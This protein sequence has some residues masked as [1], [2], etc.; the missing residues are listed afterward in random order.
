MADVKGLNTKG[1]VTPMRNK[2][3]QQNATL[4]LPFVKGLITGFV[5]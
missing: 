1:V 4:R 3:S 5:I 2:Y